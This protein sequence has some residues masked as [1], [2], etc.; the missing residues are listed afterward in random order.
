MRVN[1]IFVTTHI[2]SYS[3]KITF[4]AFAKFYPY[5]HCTSQIS[6]LFYSK[7]KLCSKVKTNTFINCHSLRSVQLAHVPH[8]DIYLAAQSVLRRFFDKYFAPS[9][10]RFI[11]ISLALAT[12]R[13]TMQIFFESASN[14]RRKIAK[15]RWNFVE[16]SWEQRTNFDEIRSHYFCTVLYTRY[17]QTVE[18]YCVCYRF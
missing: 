9:N 4:W 15:Y 10:L 8:A 11:E 13:L 18:K 6:L 14:F 5:V 7:R 3:N 16:N 1:T 2:K 17:N 12:F